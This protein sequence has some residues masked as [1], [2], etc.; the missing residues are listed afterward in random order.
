MDNKTNS[1]FTIHNS[2]LKNG[3]KKTEIGVIPEDWD[4]INFEKAFNFLSTASYSRAE[5]SKSS[6]IKYVHYG[7]IHTKLVHFL[8]FKNFELPY[9]KDKQLKT[10]S[11]IKEGDLIMADASEDYEGIGKSVE[12]KNI[13]N[14]KAI[15]GL[16]T[17]LLRGKEHIFSNG[18]KAYLYSNKIIKDQYDKLATGLKVYGVS[19]ANLKKVLI[20]LPPLPE[21]KAIAEVLSDTDELIQTLEKQIAKKRQIKQGAMQVLLSPPAT[22]QMMNDELSMVNEKQKWEVKSI[23][24]I[25]RNIIDFRGVTPKKKG[26]EW[27]NGNIVALSA[28][29]VKKGYIDFNS[30]CYL[31]SEELYKKWMTNG[32][33]EK[34]DIVFTMEAPLGNVALIPDNRKYILSQRTILLQF[35]KEKYSSHFLFQILLSQRF[36][37]YINN[38]STGSTAKGIKRKTFEKLLLSFPLLS[39]QTRIA[40][41]LSDM[42][43]E[44]VVLENKLAKYRKLKQGMMQELLTGKTRLMV[45]GKW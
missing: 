2:P 41:I 44:I 16:H 29:N 6:Q 36:E 27:G 32:N 39:E 20:P 21:Q 18:F 14:E 10:Y 8:D 28:G 34:Y 9:I 1:Q 26:L 37:K 17:F 5:V 3:Y 42:D 12:V 22:T 30:E 13:L 19:K 38:S 24:S 45:N 33:A 43:S 15:S 4:L 11:L 7:D 40:T 31:G 35:D 25:T 23:Q